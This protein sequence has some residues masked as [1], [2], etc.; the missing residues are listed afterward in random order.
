V[1]EQ[2]VTRIEEPVLVAESRAPAPPPA[3][4]ADPKALLSNSGLVMIET[5][6]SRSKSYQLEDEPVQLGRPR[7]ERQKQTAPDE[8]MQVETKN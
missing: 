1:A 6:P 5:D 3:P 4:Q 2:V 7:R 8:L